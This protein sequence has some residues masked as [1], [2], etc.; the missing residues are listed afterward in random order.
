MNDL[1]T[2]AKQIHDFGINLFSISDKITYKNF[3]ASNI[4]KSPCHSWEQL[5]TNRQ[6]Q[7]DLK[8]IPWSDA[9]GIGIVLGYGNLMAI[10][11]DGVF[12][13]F[14]PNKICKF[15]DLPI[16]Y[17][18][19]IESGSKCGFHIILEVTDLDKKN[20]NYHIITDGDYEYYFLPSMPNGKIGYSPFAS[21]SGN[22]YYPKE[23]SNRAFNKMEFLW[24]AN[25][26]IPPSLHVTGERYE[27]INGFPKYSPRQVSIKKLIQL[28]ENY[29]SFQPTEMSYIDSLQVHYLNIAGEDTLDYNY[30]MYRKENNF[31][32]HIQIYKVENKNQLHL[33]QLSW[34]VLDSSNNVLKRKTFNYLSKNIKYRIK[35]TITY[36][37]AL[38][39][40][41]N[42]RSVLHEFIYD[43]NHNHEIIAFN[44][45]VVE[46]VK[47]EI[48]SAGLF[49]DC[50]E[51]ISTNEDNVQITSDKKIVLIQ[52][53]KESIENMY[54]SCNSEKI[55]RK[56]NSLN[57]LQM[58]LCIYYSKLGVQFEAPIYEFDP[59]K[60]IEYFAINNGEPT[61]RLNNQNDNFEINSKY[62]EYGGAYGYDD[63]TINSA[64]DGDPENYWNID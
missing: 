23:N 46:F 41:T 27:F 9:C 42:Q 13:K 62:E 21:S 11:F 48:L 20:S 14:L 45:D 60:K 63:D 57:K 32:F 1:Y 17:N 39:I 55:I 2:I 10:D 40:S 64:F 56:L 26:V 49:N 35:S 31:L 25:L 34:Y 29:C 58:L 28:K 36:E 52:V 61:F 22:A 15:L 7:D 24:Q 47:K 30:S 6:S 38:I 8:K 16:D 3:D 12:D 43:L 51:D 44:N 19:I 37:K 5:I 50:F 53:E 4:L 18:W 59:E 54:Y 33:V